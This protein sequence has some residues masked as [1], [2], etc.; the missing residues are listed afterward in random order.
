M[1]R[2]TLLALGIVATAA[3]SACAGTPSAPAIS[4]PREILIRA[5]ENAQAATSVHFRADIAGN[6]SLDLTGVGT[7][8]RGGGLDLTGT[9]VEGDVDIAG[10]KVKASFSAPSLFDITGDAIV[11]GTDTY[12]R[13]SL[14]GDKYRKSSALAGGTLGALSDP[15]QTIADLKTSLDRLPEPPVRKPDEKCGDRDCYRVTVSVPSTDVG[16]ALGSAID[17]ALGGQSAAPGSGGSPVPGSGGSPVPGV[18]A[19]PAVT[20]GGSVDVWVTKDN[21]QPARLAITADG[22]SLGKLTVTVQLT[23][24]GAGVSI[25]APPADEV[26]APSPSG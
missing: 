4:D 5:V 24:W 7:G 14:L 17:G 6:V 22:G 23:G 9:T 25:V 3:L 11:I 20:G 19:M 8:G 10:G 13:V 2:R 21:L 15:K 26:A 1:S 16:G 12:L 18:S